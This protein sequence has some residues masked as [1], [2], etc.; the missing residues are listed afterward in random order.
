M[1]AG[2]GATV[3]AAL[4]VGVGEGVALGAGDADGDGDATAAWDGAVDDGALDGVGAVAEGE[5]AH[6]KPKN[7]A[8]ASRRAPMTVIA[9]THSHPSRYGHR[10]GLLG[11]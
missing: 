2:V 4:A 11:G 8:S 7:A 5:H 1:G 3:G 6:A 10:S 9:S